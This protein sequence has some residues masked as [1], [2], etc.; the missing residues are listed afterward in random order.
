MFES[1][2]VK[3]SVAP[4]YKQPTFKSEMVTQ[5]IIWEELEVL[6]KQDNW[7]K[8]K[9]WDEYVS[10]IHFSYLISS[11]KA[12]ENLD[13]K[14]LMSWC[15]MLDFDSNFMYGLGENNRLKLPYGSLVPIVNLGRRYNFI[16]L[17]GDNPYESHMSSSRHLMNYD[18][19]IKKGE[20][21]KLEISKLLISQLGT[22]YLWGGKTS[23]GYDCSGFVQTI[24]KIKG[25]DFPRDCSQQIKSPLLEEIDLHDA[26]VGDIVFFKENKNISHVGIFGDLSILN[27]LKY[28][29]INDEV[30]SFFHCSG[31]VK[32]CS[33]NHKTNSWDDSSLKSKFHS[34]HRIKNGIK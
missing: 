7:F 3:T 14:E 4:L 28:E 17:P 13:K 22:Q 16:H 24:L 15:Y 12:K 19:L 1:V 21:D 2:I 5:A 8:V 11:D 20:E 25:I 23:F 29:S 32:T 27:H 34:I 31:D 18:K 33:I 6:D 30:I 10:W 26:D 9:Q